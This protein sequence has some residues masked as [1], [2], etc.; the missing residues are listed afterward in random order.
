M[1]TVVFSSADLCRASGRLFPIV[2]EE[3]RIINEASSYFDLKWE[4]TLL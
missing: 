3:I 4:M 1:D 2:G